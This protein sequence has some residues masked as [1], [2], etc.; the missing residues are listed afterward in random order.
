[1][2]RDQAILLVRL[3]EKRELTLMLERFEK[4]RNKSPTDLD[5]GGAQREIPAPSEPNP[6]GP[7]PS[8]RLSLESC[9][10]REANTRK[11]AL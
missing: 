2:G 3:F 7:P 4:P 9:E 6:Y 10:L 1:M 5:L 11:R 8:A